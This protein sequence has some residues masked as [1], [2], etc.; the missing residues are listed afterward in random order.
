VVELADGPLGP[1][2]AVNAGSF[3]CD[4]TTFFAVVTV[5]G[6]GSA[7]LVTIDVDTG[8]ITTIGPTLPYLDALAWFC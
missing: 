7:A 6:S 8:A 3:A 2:S 1:G 4:G 5:P